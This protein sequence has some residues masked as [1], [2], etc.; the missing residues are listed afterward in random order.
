MEAVQGPVSVN[1]L[2]SKANAVL[3]AG[4]RDHDDI[5]IG[6]SHCAE[7]GAGCSWDSYHACALHTVQHMLDVCVTDV[8]RLRHAGNCI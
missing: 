5:D 8:S 4:L 1:L 3:T 7:E 2:D 6:V